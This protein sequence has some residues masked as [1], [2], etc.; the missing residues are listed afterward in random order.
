MDLSGVG[1][2]LSQGIQ[3]VQALQSMKQTSLAMEGEKKRQALTDMEGTRKKQEMEFMNTPMAIDDIYASAGLTKGDPRYEY[4]DKI[5]TPHTEEL[6]GKRIIRTRN[7]TSAMEI[8]KIPKFIEGAKMAGLQ[9]VESQ[10]ETLD[11][12]IL[13]MPDDNKKKAELIGKR[14][15]LS[16]ARTSKLAEIEG[17]QKEHE[18]SVT[19]YGIDAEEYWNGNLSADQLQERLAKNKRE[20]LRP[21]AGY[22]PSY[23][24]VGVTRDNVAVLMDERTGTYYINTPQGKI[25][26]TGP[27]KTRQMAITEKTESGKTD[28]LA[29]AARFALDKGLKLK[30]DVLDWSDYL[31]AYAKKRFKD[32]D[33]VMEEAWKEYKSAGKKEKPGLSLPGGE[34]SELGRLLEAIKKSKGK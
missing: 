1:I 13:E 29:N 4:L 25:A 17:F 12:Q 18:A 21:E 6:N 28:R 20:S 23:K 30:K 19:K 8:M 3:N 34:G 22:T 11:Q 2:G 15:Q 9:S 31:S 7:L 32:E 33:Q 27:F 24:D 14:R 16:A 5:L 10:I 26:Y